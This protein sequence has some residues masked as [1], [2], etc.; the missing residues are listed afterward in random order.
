MRSKK[1]QNSSKTARRLP[2]QR[3]HI[4]IQR[5]SQILAALALQKQAKKYEF[6][7]IDIFSTDLS[8]AKALVKWLKE[9]HKL[10]I[11]K[12]AELL[13]RDASSISITYKDAR[14]EH[15]ALLSPKQEI[16]IPISLFKDRSRAILEHLVLY[17]KDEQG[18]NLTTIS[19]LLGKHHST[20]STAYTRG[21]RK[22]A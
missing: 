21:R 22:R 14:T 19:T 18:L 3:L 8:P 10:S 9:N 13:N 4:L 2:K 17:V 20:V 7:P 11:T 6:V 16:K 5:K 12:I 15:P 1:D